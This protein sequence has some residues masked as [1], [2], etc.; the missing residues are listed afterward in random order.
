MI[1]NPYL[2]PARIQLGEGDIVSVLNKTV[3]LLDQFDDMLR[4]YDDVTLMAVVA[5]SRRLLVRGLVAMMRSGDRL[6]VPIPV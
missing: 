3:D 6:S 1:T 4:V 2:E 5:E